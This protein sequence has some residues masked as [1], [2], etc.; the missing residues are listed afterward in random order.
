MSTKICPKC[1]KSHSLNGKFCS[2]SCANSRGPRTEEFKKKVSTKMKGKN[3]HTEESIRAGILSKGLIPS[4]DK[5]N[6]I[7]I[8]C[9]KDTNSKVKKTCSKDC[10]KIYNTLRSQQNPN[11]G[12]Q[13][14][15]HRS[16]IANI[17]GEIFVSESSYE[18]K[19]SEIL[20]ELNIHWIRPNYF[21]YQDEKGNKRRYYP[22]FYLPEYDMYLDPKN[23][24][25]IKTDIDKINRTAL[26]NNVKIVV[27][28]ERYLTKEFI[29]SLVGDRGNAPL[30]PACK[31]G[32]L[33]LS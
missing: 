15:T 5:P 11:C 3:F 27:L 10:Y 21:W 16:K 32:T 24:Y 13:K 20:N 2:R 29:E 12:G 1:N 26:Q 25:L 23:N 28:G 6:T 4:T 19:I 33:L 30:L 14:H 9:A 18:V 31:T 22:D 7:C 17:K 8:I